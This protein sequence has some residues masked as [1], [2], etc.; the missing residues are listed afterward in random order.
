MHGAWQA[1]ANFVYHCEA[2]LHAVYA[3]YAVYA[4]NLDTL[5]ANPFPKIHLCFLEQGFTDVC[6]SSSTLR[7]KKREACTHGGS[8][9]TGKY[10]RL[11]VNV[12]E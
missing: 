4:I 10:V 6:L 5:V 1:E 2:S 12:P 9:V 11:V 7:E 8:S 3:V